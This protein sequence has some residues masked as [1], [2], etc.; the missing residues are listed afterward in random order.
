M[1]HGCGVALVLPS[2][3]NIALKGLA[4]NLIGNASG[5][6]STLQ[7]LSGA[8]GIA[9]TG[10]VFYHM[11]KGQDDFGSYYDAF[12]YGM[13]IN[14]TCLAGVLLIL[15]LLPKSLLPKA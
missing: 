5:V 14:I 15:V 13:A 4:E 10:A 3:A 11:V 8:L 12:L 9:L 1:L 6:Y 7:Q 2:L